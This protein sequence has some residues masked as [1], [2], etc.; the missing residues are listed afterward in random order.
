[1]PAETTPDDVFHTYLDAWRLGL[2]SLA[3]YRD[4]SKLQQPLNVKDGKALAA[5][6]PET[7]P[8]GATRPA[9]RKLP[10]ERQSLT[11]KF[12]IAGFDG[13]IT[14][15][16]YE[17]GSQGEIFITMAKQGSVISGLMDSF[18]LAVS[19][20]LQYGVPLSV[21]VDKFAHVRFEPSGYSSNPAIVYAKSIPD[22][23]FRW[24]A[25]KFLPAE[26]RA[27][28]PSTPDLEDASVG[29]AQNDLFQGQEDAPPC[30]NCGFVMVRSGSC[31]KCQNCGSTSGCS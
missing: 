11:H 26:E 20:A 16:M 21:L 4:G 24:L 8:E 28:Q 15:G 22:Y 2:K 31:Y 10:D 14:V 9:R 29:P 19:I 18:A 17:D 30:S 6:V 25:Q 12:S 27:D 3:I 5:S 13:Y 23:V 1:M 7:P